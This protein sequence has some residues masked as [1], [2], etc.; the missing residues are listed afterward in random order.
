MCMSETRLEPWKIRTLHGPHWN[1]I[2]AK[3]EFLF[4]Q[5]RSRIC[6]GQIRSLK[7]GYTDSGSVYAKWNLVF[8]VMN[9]N[10]A[11]FSLAIGHIVTRFHRLTF[12]SKIIFPGCIK[13]GLKLWYYL[14]SDEIRTLLTQILVIIRKS[15]HKI[16]KHCLLFETFRALDNDSGL[17]GYMSFFAN[18]PGKIPVNM[19][20]CFHVM[21]ELCSLYCFV[22]VIIS[23]I[24]LIAKTAKTI[25]TSLY[26]FR[27]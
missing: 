26:S 12:F 4:G 23:S 10:W 13:M 2:K 16:K 15:S 5:G 1:L 3:L 17:P 7:S 27:F 18:Q 22:F 25:A 6:V 9:F 21:K 11:Y 20:P 14:T 24:K 8:Q 19:S